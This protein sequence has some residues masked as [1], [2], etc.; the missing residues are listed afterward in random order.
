MFEHVFE[1][2]PVIEALVW[3]DPDRKRPLAEKVEAAAR[4]FRERL[5]AQPNLCLVHP[6]EAG[7]HPRVVVRPDPR[8]LRHHYWVGIDDQLPRRRRGA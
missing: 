7:S 6:S 3:F 4:R 2:I 8:V 5:G 1:V